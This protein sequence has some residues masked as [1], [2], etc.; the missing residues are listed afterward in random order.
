MPVPNAIVLSAPPCW[1]WQVVSGEKT[2]DEEGMEQE[3]ELM[4]FG[5]SDK[6]SPYPNAPVGKWSTGICGCFEHIPSCFV[7]CL[8]PCVTVGQV[9][10]GVVLLSEIFD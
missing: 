5:F 4:E 1:Y 3:E 10:A 8:C 6:T 7:A 2:I 9:R